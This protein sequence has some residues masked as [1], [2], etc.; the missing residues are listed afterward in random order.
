MSLIQTESINWTE[1]ERDE[2]L[3]VAESVN[4]HIENFYQHR[5]QGQHAKMKAIGELEEYKRKHPQRSKAARLIAAGYKAEE[6]SDA[7]ISE[8]ATAYREYLNL[9]SMN[10]KKVSKFAEN[11]PVFLLV[12]MGRQQEQADRCSTFNNL[13]DWSETKHV[14]ALW[15][16]AFTYW[17]RHHKYPTK[18]QVRGF[19]AGYTTDEF[20]FLSSLRP[21]AESSDVRKL[22]SSEPTEA[23]TDSTRIQMELLATPTVDVFEPAPT[24]TDLPA[25]LPATDR[26]QRGID[27]LIESL[28]M[29]GSIDELWV[30]PHYLEQIKPHRMTLEMLVDVCTPTTP[31]RWRR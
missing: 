25:A 10:D 11:A 12:L 22:S 1:D 27:M 24:T 30:K 3:P 7:T 6:W 9:Q 29:I 16:A 17:K 14:M 26:V 15:Y 23:P 4:R 18:K 5:Q 31:V 28:R 8:N 21:K 20:V 13:D 19:L 2:F